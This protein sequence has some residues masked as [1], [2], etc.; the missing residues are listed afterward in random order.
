MDFFSILQGVDVRDTGPTNVSQMPIHVASGKE[1]KEY[2][3]GCTMLA[4]KIQTAVG[5]VFSKH[6][7]EIK[8]VI[9]LFLLLM[10]FAYFGYA[11]YYKFGDEGSIRLLVCSLLGVMFLLI[12]I[13]QRLGRSTIGTFSQKGGLNC[14]GLKKTRRY[15]H[16]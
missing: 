6:G 12:H 10:Y 1:D 3:T 16:R 5:V 8:F 9:K 7:N 14:K 13:F 11:M 4:D 2:F 15:V